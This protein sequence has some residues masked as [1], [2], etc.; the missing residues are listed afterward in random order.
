MAFSRDQD[1]I[2]WLSHGDRFMNCFPSIENFKQ[3]FS[4][5]LSRTSR[6]RGDFMNNFPW[7][8]VIRI[9]IRDDRDIGTRSHKGTKRST[10]S[11]ITPTTTFTKD[12]QNPCVW[13][14]CNGGIQRLHTRRLRSVINQHTKRLTLVDK[15][16]TPGNRVNTPNAFH[17]LLHINSSNITNS[18]TRKRIQ[19]VVATC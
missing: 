13:N 6:T 1:E 11:P 18:N 19:D 16:Q 7:I 10:T 3:C 9:F 15:L 12:M 2:V 17:G 8:I 14:R 5:F 4:I